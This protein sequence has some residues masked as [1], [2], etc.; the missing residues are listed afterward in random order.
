M[1]SD[2]V[3]LLGLRARGRHGW[4]EHETRDGQTFVV[5]VVL[6]VDTRP[7]AASDDLADTVD[8]SVVAANVIALIEGTPRKLVETLAQHIA[9]ACLA[10]PRVGAV[11]V[12]VHKPEAPLDVA[13]DDVQVR[14]VRSR[15]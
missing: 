2:T 13:F 3:A 7:A 4:F 11:E 6:H 12:V 1:S 8:Y 14:I 5:D 15:A 10:D 9:A